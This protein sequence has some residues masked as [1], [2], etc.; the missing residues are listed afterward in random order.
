[1]PGLHRG[2]CR[3]PFGDAASSTTKAFL[4][5]FLE[6]AA[7]LDLA[8]DFPLAFTAFPLA[9]AAL[10]GITSAISHISERLHHGVTHLQEDSINLR[11]LPRYAFMSMPHSTS[12]MPAQLSHPDEPAR[13]RLESG[14]PSD[15]AAGDAA[16]GSA[17]GD[18]ASTAAGG[19]AG[20]AAAAVPSPPDSSL[21]TSCTSLQHHA[22]ATSCQPRQR[23]R[24][25]LNHS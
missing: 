25:D 4:R 18:G 20:A 21:G 23:P 13:R 14:R 16:A 24:G 2:C 1:M 8:I 17:A 5:G 9:F 19:D 12:L 15:G 7:A 3:R 6:M 10:L 22:F 11:Q